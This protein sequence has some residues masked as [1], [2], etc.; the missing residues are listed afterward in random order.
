MATN[1]KIG[2]GSELRLGDGASPQV[3][4]KVADITNV[5]PVGQTAAEVEVTPIDAL[6]REYIG[7][8]K[9]GNSVSITANYVASN[10][11]HK[12]FRDG[13]GTTHP[14]EIAWADGESARFN[15][16]QTSFERGETTA[17]GVLTATIEGRISGAI[18]WTDAS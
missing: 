3:Y 18:T 16:V 7:G 13:V 17:E 12:T 1:A 2:A 4:T 9:E 5:G 11:D 14:L 8:L 6:E 15:F 10:A